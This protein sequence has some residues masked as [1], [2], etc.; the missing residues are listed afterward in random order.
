MPADTAQSR[1][2]SNGG[3]DVHGF[4]SLAAQPVLRCPHGRIGTP[5]K[6]SQHTRDRR[7]RDRELRVLTLDGRPV[8]DIMV[9][10]R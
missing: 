5:A 7:S 3:V 9:R 4:R 8:A 6:G 2:S 1:R 10:R